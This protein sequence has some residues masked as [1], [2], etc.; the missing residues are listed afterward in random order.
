MK[1]VSTYCQPT[2]PTMGGYPCDAADY[3]Y[4]RGMFTKK[5]KI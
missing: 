2:T 3:G 4:G 1:Q 5:L